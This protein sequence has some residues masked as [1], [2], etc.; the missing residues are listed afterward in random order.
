MSKIIWPYIKPDPQSL[1]GEFEGR[2]DYKSM[3]KT[4]SEEYV[5]WLEYSLTFARQKKYESAPTANNTAS[6]KFP[7]PHLDN[8]GGCI[9][10][11]GHKKCTCMD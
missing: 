1:R 7:C 4:F 5:E 6:P 9:K 11:V 10:T 3:S 2:H 8:V